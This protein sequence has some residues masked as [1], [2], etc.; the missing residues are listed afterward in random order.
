MTMNAFHYENGE[1]VR[2]GDRVD[3]RRIMR[4]PARGVVVA[5]YDPS[6]PSPPKGINEYGVTIQL[7]E[8]EYLFTSNN[9]DPRVKLIERAR[10]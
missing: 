10:E 3:V 1:I 2:V 8:N 5:V 9:P 4:R 7:S 6:I